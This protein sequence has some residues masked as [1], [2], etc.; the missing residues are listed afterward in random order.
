MRPP[1][2]GALIL[3]LVPFVAVCFSVSLWDR[4]HPIVLGLPF[5]F[6]WLMLWIALTPLFL[7]ASY[8]LEA[9]RDNEDEMRRAADGQK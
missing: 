3:G 8:W 6:F 5:N 4:I 7:W 1:S 2:L 9:P